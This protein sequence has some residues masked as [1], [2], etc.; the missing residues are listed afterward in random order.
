MADA[1][2]LEASGSG[3]TANSTAW[4]DVATIAAGSFTASSEYL[5]L[6][7]CVGT[8]ASSTNDIRLRLV[9]GATPTEFT[10][11]Y[12]AEEVLTTTQ[13][14]SAGWLV[15]MTQGGATESVRVQVSSSSTTVATAV[16]AHIIAIRLADLGTEDT[17]WRWAEITADLTLTTAYQD[18]ASETF[19]PN[20]TDKYLYIGQASWIPG[21]TS[22]Q[23]DVALEVDGT[24]RALSSEEGEDTTNERRNRLLVWAET[25]TAASHTVKVRAK[26]ETAAGTVQSSRL[27]V[28]NLNRLAQAAIATDVGPTDLVEGSGWINLAATSIAPAATG[29]FVLI[30]SMAQ[31]WNAAPSANPQGRL[32][33]DP[34]GSGLV[35]RPA[36][37]DTALGADTWDGTDERQLV[38]F[39]VV[40]LTSGASR[41][42]NLDGQM[43]NAGTADPIVDE[44][45]LVAF[46]V[47]LP[48]SGTTHDGAL[49]MAGS[50][51]VAL[52]GSIVKPGALPASGTGSIV[53]AGGLVLSGA[54]S[55]TGSGAV[56]E[57]ARMTHGAK[58]DPAGS[59]AV[60]QGGGLYKQGVLALAGSLTVALGGT[61]VK[62]GALTVAAGASVS[63]AATIRHGGAFAPAGSGALDI[64]AR[65]THGGGLAVSGTGSLSAGASDVEQGT[66]ATT[67]TATLGA[68]A[69]VYRQGST[70]LAGSG[71]LGASAGL[72]KGA[73]L[74]ATGAGSLGLSGG[75]VVSASLAL[76]G[77]G[78]L[79]ADAI[80]SNLSSISVA[81][82]GSIS[83]GG[84]VVTGGA[85]VIAGSGSL[86][87]S[88][89]RRAG[90]ALSGSGTG[91]A[92]LGGGVGM[93]GSFGSAGSGV[94]VLV[95]DILAPYVPL[96][97]GAIA[98]V[99]LATGSGIVR[100]VDQ[101]VSLEGA[102]AKVR[103]V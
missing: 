65:M 98:S 46:S 73:T 48:A 60:T 102:R 11:A 21:S 62:P 7:F 17:H 27:F 92:G 25:P 90:G 78:S 64:A 58:L 56:S 54:L 69:G 71:A 47:A 96:D 6:A 45:V 75:R 53:E 3:V 68:A 57:A 55:A 28:L 43:A 8:N 38:L 84:S 76:V 81:G 94:L 40:Q 18:G 89:S 9:R 10:D 42:I 2:V 80:V 29:N 85:V 31:K 1:Q 5:I 72:V 14:I 93:I 41:T 95:G 86:S 4:V 63:L 91:T 101:A 34:D 79:S 74:A 50:G 49:S 12:D 70:G 13:R 37:G 52:G 22:A 33:V 88:G 20:G 77:S 87:A 67:A 61:V 24:I 23:T 19:T 36:Y 100:V 59:G 16:Y 30:G 82:S 26:G 103:V 35:S 15:R 66:L 99:T 44:R 83:L 39:D 51:S 97:P 32:Q